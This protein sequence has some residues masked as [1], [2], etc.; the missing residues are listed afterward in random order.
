MKKEVIRN[1]IKEHTVKEK[2]KINDDTLVFKE[3]FVDSMGF[4][5]LIDFLEEKYAVKT[6]DL[7]LIE[8]NFESINAISDFITRKLNGNK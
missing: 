8:E 7:D 5:M 3:G 2:E 6:E 4:V 1:Y